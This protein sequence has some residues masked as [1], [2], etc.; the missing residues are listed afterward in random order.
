VPGPSEDII[1]AAIAEAEA[2]RA[3]MVA[4]GELF[5]L[6][7]LL[8]ETQKQVIA[9]LNEAGIPEEEFLPEHKAQLASAMRKIV[10]WALTVADNNPAT[11]RKGYGEDGGIVTTPV[12]GEIRFPFSGG[13]PSGPPGPVGTPGTPPPGP[14]GPDDEFFGWVPDGEQ[15]RA[16]DMMEAVAAETGFGRY[17][18][19]FP[20]VR[21]V[22]RALGG[23]WGLNGKRGNP[24]D[25]SGDILA[26]DFP[27]YQPQLF[28]VLI[29]GGGKNQ[30]TWSALPYP[31]RYGAIW[32][33]P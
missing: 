28:D 25:P 21:A 3:K 24:N 27:G 11:H 10:Q 12:T 33:A 30:L 29:D 19:P 9:Q 7:G 22:A 5:N 23:N 8:K 32:I 6:S 18:E 14:K 4:S 31:Q 13:G 15:D 1:L 20:F 17:D 2:R 16:F 26:Y